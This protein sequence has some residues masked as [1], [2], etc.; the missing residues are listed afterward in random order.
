MTKPQTG[1]KGYLE[2]PCQPGA[3]GAGAGVGV[4]V[5]V[6]RGMHVDNPD[7]PF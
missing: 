2:V 1:S 5:G 7:F 3:G 6:G 4:G